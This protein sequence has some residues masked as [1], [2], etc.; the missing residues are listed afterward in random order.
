[1]CI[2]DS[3]KREKILDLLALDQ[4][5]DGTWDAGGQLPAQKRPAKETSLVSSS[6]IALSAR[7]KVSQAS[8]PTIRA[9]KEGKSIEWY[10]VNL[11]LSSRIGDGKVNTFA[12]KLK[13]FQNSDGGWGW[14]VNDPSDALGTG[15]ALY[16]CLLYTSPSPR[17]ATL[18][19]MPSSA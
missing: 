3:S 14:L 2:R 15:M 4:K 11:L 7:Q 12:N 6:W 19:R 10:V 18:S 17:D 16:A 9:Q 1:M 5:K 8:I 13:E